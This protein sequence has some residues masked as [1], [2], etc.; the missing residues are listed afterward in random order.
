METN[1]STSLKFYVIL[2]NVWVLTCTCVFV[3]RSEDNLWKLVA[4]CH[5]V[6]SRYRTQV[7][8]LGGRHLYLLSHLNPT[9]PPLDSH[10]LFLPFPLGIVTLIVSLL[11]FS[12]KAL[13][14][15]TQV[16]FQHQELLYASRMQK[17]WRK[18]LWMSLSHMIDSFA[19]CEQLFVLCCEDRQAL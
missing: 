18:H 4:S 14:L 2:L 1:N 13:I 5:H 8:R 10:H 6:V 19:N 9:I 11:L 12:G 7:L 15:V 16:L 17:D 3:Y